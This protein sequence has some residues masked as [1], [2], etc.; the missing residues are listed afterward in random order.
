MKRSS[1]SLILM[2]SSWHFSFLSLLHNIHCIT[3][4]QPPRTG[5]YNTCICESCD[6]LL[7][8]YVVIYSVITFRCMH[9]SSSFLV[10]FLSA[11]GDI[12]RRG[13]DI[14]RNSKPLLCIYLTVCIKIPLYSQRLISDKVAIKFSCNR[15]D[16]HIPPPPNLTKHLRQIRPA[17]SMLQ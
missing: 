7:H 2:N 17:S 4:H 3:C 8:A 13:F 15:V 10:M 14:T 5:M 6:S 11:L 9:S 12:T 16:G 1:N